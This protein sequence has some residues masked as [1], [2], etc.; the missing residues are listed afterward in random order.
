MSRIPPGRTRRVSV[1]QRKKLTSAVLESLHGVLKDTGPRDFTLISSPSPDMQ[2]KKAIYEN[3]LKQ[4]EN[5]YRRLRDAYL[6]GIDSLEDYKESRGGLDRRRE[7][8]QQLL[9]KLP[10]LKQLPKPTAAGFPGGYIPLRKSW[11]AASLMS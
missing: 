8:L 5:K 1:Y 10:P 11:R 2:S 7:E 9:E 6:N 3:E 4:L